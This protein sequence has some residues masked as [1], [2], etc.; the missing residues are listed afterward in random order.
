[1]ILLNRKEINKMKK[2][3]IA[4]SLLI[5]STVCFAQPVPHWNQINALSEQI[6]KKIAAEKPAKP[7]Q[8]VGNSAVQ[9][10]S[11]NGQY[12]KKVIDTFAA[13]TNAGLK[14][15][16]YT[17][18]KANY[19]ADQLVKGGVAVAY[20]KYVDA[21]KKY[22]AQLD[23]QVRSYTTSSNGFTESQISAATQYKQLISSIKSKKQKALQERAALV[24]YLNSS[25][26]SV[27]NVM[28]YLIQNKTSLSEQ[29]EQILNSFIN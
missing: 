20:I 27:G 29:N 28:V 2:G 24:N 18:S 1:M 19:I 16:Q 12:F 3:I 10:L 21:Q 23:A 6:G 25:V 11:V 14:E 9:N 15:K 17:G 26:P 7:V 13:K 4:V 8:K 5:V 22:F